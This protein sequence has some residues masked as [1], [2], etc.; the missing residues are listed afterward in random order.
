MLRE[1]RGAGVE[2]C[3][4]NLTGYYTGVVLVEAMI[5]GKVRFAWELEGRRNDFQE[6]KNVDF[7]R[8]GLI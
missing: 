4:D 8:T 7:E 1:E 5:Q 6:R 3:D 2:V